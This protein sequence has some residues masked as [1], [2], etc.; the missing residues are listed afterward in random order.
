MTS[1]E[2]FIYEF[3]W[4]SPH[5]L[6]KFSN[7]PRKAKDPCF[8]QSTNGS[9]HTQQSPFQWLHSS[10]WSSSSQTLGVLSARAVVAAGFSSHTSNPCKFYRT[11]RWAPSKLK[12]KDV[13]FLKAFEFPENDFIHI[14]RQWEGQALWIDVA[15]CCRTM[16]MEGHLL[17]TL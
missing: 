10:P 8:P 3:Y 16:E 2:G 7:L 11:N 12:N 9:S 6:K 14:S 1:R 5:F 4:R 13:P 15:Y 17:S